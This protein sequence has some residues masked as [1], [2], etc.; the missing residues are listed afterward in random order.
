MCVCVSF[1][2]FVFWVSSSVSTGSFDHACWH[3]FPLNF[4]LCMWNANEFGVWLMAY[5]LLVDTVNCIVGMCLLPNL[6]GSYFREDPADWLLLCCHHHRLWGAISLP[7]FVCDSCSVYSLWCASLQHPFKH[8]AYTI[9]HN[10]GT[11]AWG[12]KGPVCQS[13]HR[14]SFHWL[15][16]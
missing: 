5:A 8:W 3:F 16:S 11:H 10:E 6:N 13:A 4:T 7:G 9:W 14:K 1:T 12:D 2:V 15:I